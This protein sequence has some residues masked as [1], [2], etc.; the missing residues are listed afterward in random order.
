MRRAAWKKS[1]VVHQLRLAVVASFLGAGHAGAQH[2][3]NFPFTLG[4]PA[5]FSRA[6]LNG[7]TARGTLLALYDRAAW[8][9]T[10]A[11]RATSPRDGLV[12]GYLARQGPDGLLKRR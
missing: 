7:I 11:V 2:P 8:H 12:E 5:D 9:A 3:G 1:V 10:D 4:R 6:E